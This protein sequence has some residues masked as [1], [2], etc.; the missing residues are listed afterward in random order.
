MTTNYERQQIAN[1]VWEL[2][3]DQVKSLF[4]NWLAATDASLTDFE[5]LLSTD[6]A[7]TNAAETWVY[8]ELDRALN[9]QPMTEDQMAQQSLDALEEYRNSGNGVSQA[10]LQ[11]WAD[12]RVS[13]AELPYS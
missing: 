5:K 10:R 9:F 4:L 13:N 6:Y 11:E 7:Q 2:E 1:H 12:R 8:G 3:G